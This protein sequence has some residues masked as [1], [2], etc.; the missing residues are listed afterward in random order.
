MGAAV[1]TCWITPLETS[2]PDAT[3]LLTEED[4]EDEEGPGAVWVD[5][6]ITTETLVLEDGVGVTTTTVVVVLTLL[7]VLVVVEALPVSE[8]SG[9]I[10]GTRE[11]FGRPLVELD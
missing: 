2:V 11:V 3:F 1:G 10:G 7:R 9:G 4:E 6:D 8:V 5:V